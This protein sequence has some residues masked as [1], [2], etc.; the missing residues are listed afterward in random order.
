M[1]KIT[2]YYSPDADDAFMMY[3]LSANAVELNN[4][5]VEIK[6]DDIEALNQLAKLNKLDSTAASVHAYAYLY[7]DYN[8]LTT[9]ASFAGENYGPRLLTKEAIDLTSSKKL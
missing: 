6:R 4:F 7:K 8:I 3:G 5:D 9:A 2:I 1:K